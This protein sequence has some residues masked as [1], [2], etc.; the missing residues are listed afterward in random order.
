MYRLVYIR[1]AEKEYN[2]GESNLYKHDPGITPDG[3]SKTKEMAKNIIKEWGVPEM[4]ISSPYRRTRETAIIMNTTLREYNNGNNTPNN[5]KQN[6]KLKIDVGL[7][8]Y[9]GNHKTA[10]LDVTPETKVWNPP[11]PEMFGA[12]KQRVKNHYNKIRKFMRKSNK[13]N[14]NGNGEMKVIWL[15]THGII[16]KQIH[17]EQTGIKL[18]KQQLP[19]LT[20]LSIVDEGNSVKTEFKSLNPKQQEKYELKEKE[21]NYEQ[22]KTN[23]NSYEQKNYEKKNYEKKNYEKKNY[24]KKNYEKKNYEKKNYEKKNYEKKNINNYEQKRNNKSRK[25]LWVEPKEKKNI[26]KT[27][28]NVMY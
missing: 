14:S 13:N 28:V 17:E 1:H 9:L 25:K 23:T 26:P 24:E 18:H 19:N 3:I 5:N 10:I 12:M 2:N 20:C 6:I 16:I 27:Y 4:I 7:S 8:E 15:V 11:H 22:K 21:T